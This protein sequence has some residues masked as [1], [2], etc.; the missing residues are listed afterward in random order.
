MYGSVTC[1][2]DYDYHTDKEWKELYNMVQNDSLDYVLELLDNKLKQAPKD[3]RT[4]EFKA[5][6]LAMA[7]DT[8]ASLKGLQEALSLT[9]RK[10]YGYRSYLYHDIA[11]VYLLQADTVSAIKSLKKSIKSKQPYRNSYIDLADLF[12]FDGAFDDAN[13]IYNQMSSKFPKDPLPLYG[14]ARSAYNMDHFQEAMTYIEQSQRLSPDAIMPL[15]LYMRCFL[16]MEDF[17]C[18]LDKAMD[19]LEKVSYDPEAME[20]LEQLS[21]TIPIS[22]LFSLKKNMITDV[23]NEV[24][25][26]VILA[27]NYLYQ[28]DY[29]NALKYFTELESEAELSQDIPL[30][31]KLHCY[32]NMDNPIDELPVLEKLIDIDPSDAYYYLKRSDAYFYLGNY[33]KAKSDLQ[34]ALSLDEEYACWIFYKLGW[35]DEM[36]GDMMGALINYEMSIDYNPDNAYS[37]LMKANL[38]NT[39]FNRPEEAKIEYETIIQLDKGLTDNTCKQYAYAALGEYEKA[40]EI[41][42]AIIQKYNTAGNYY[43]AACLYT[44]MA[45]YDEAISFLKKA[46]EMGYKKYAHIRNDDAL[47]PLQ[48]TPQFEI[49]LGKYEK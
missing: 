22:V 4:Y 14:L 10:E 49:I 24:Y 19:I 16:R 38:L 21:D 8:D 42:E 47:F 2:P 39:Y 7:G 15:R 44:R 43:D 11:S 28:K 45:K 33:E 5:L 1:C 46:L 6:V 35:I 27:Q 31:G 40:I 9:S 32:E 34:K 30:S 25:W 13:Y 48:K 18:S 37:H 36:R 12:F 23:K 17:K 20:T 3:P 41:M 26:K 29:V